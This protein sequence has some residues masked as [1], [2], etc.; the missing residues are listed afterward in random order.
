MVDGR[1][2]LRD[3]EEMACIDVRANQKLTLN[4]GKES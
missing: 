1:L 4:S 3:F 2:I